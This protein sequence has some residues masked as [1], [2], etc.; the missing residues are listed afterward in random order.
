[1]GCG[2][3]VV[4]VDRSTNTEERKRPTFSDIH[5]H[6]RFENDDEHDF[7]SAKRWKFTPKT[8]FVYKWVSVAQRRKLHEQIART[9]IE[10]RTKLDNERLEEEKVQ[11]LGLTPLQIPACN[12]TDERI[13]AYTMDDTEHTRFRFQY[14][15]FK[16]GKQIYSWKKMLPIIQVKAGL[17]LK[18]V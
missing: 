17:L 8:G 18:P 9:K 15:S 4:R 13:K 5:W 6:Q 3:S 12:H 7:A 2:S 16:Y 14:D 10:E 11:E 1:M